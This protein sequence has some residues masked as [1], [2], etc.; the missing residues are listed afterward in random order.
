[1]SFKA[2]QRVGTESA[3]ILAHGTNHVIVLVTGVGSFGFL[4]P[5]AAVGD[6]TAGPTVIQRIDSIEVVAHCIFN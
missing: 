2:R 1:M 4:T 3:A 5:E 6:E